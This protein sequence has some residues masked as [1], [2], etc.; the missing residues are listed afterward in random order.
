M[1]LKHTYNLPQGY[2]LEDILS[3]PN[4]KVSY[5][6]DFQKL[7]P[8]YNETVQDIADEDPVIGINSGG[9]FCSQNVLDTSKKYTIKW[10]LWN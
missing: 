3:G 2:D 6:R 9:F 8:T 5:I 4:C 1:N 7:Y 10:I